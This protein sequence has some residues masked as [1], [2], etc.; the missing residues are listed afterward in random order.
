MVDPI[1]L[2]Q[3]LTLPAGAIS[4]K[5]IV[6]DGNNG[7]IQIYN[8]ADQLVVLIDPTG[9]IEIFAGATG[10]QLATMDDLGFTS[11]SVAGIKN[12]RMSNT[13][14]TIFDASGTIVGN[15]DATGFDIQ[16]AGE[17]FLRFVIDS[18]GVH[19][20]GSG[21]IARDT[22]LYRGG[23]D[24]LK[25]DDT[26]NAVTDIQRNAISLP[27]GRFN[28]GANGFASVSA[29]QGGIT[30][31][32]DLTSL[33]IAPTLVS[34]RRYRVTAEAFFS[35]DTANDIPQLFIT[36]S[37]NN[38]LRE[39]RT[40]PL[41]GVG[42]IGKAEAQYDFTAGA[43]GAMTLKLRAVRNAGAS[44]I[45]LQANVAGREAYIAIDDIAVP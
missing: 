32:A 39:G 3:S 5:R 2:L 10:N 38:H 24:I 9:Y 44:T 18:V 16:G 14:L 6:L 34:G 36:D 1:A 37:A 8:A 29:N 21:T 35:S 43:S 31:E 30:T 27:R 15:W 11:F 19:S 22:N 4:G 17:A 13:G 12:A 20:W 33:S 23:A 26:F 7:N 42:I 25:T 41:V 40:A 45:T 28:A